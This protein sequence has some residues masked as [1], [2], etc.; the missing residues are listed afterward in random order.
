M[1]MEYS[2]LTASP[3][4]AQ[5]GLKKGLQSFEED[6]NKATISDLKDNLIGQVCVNMLDKCDLTSEIRKKA[7]EYLML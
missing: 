7:L 5:Y 2:D 3:T 1:I 4:K 6:G